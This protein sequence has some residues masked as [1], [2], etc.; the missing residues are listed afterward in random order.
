[1]DAAAATTEYLPLSEACESYREAWQRLVADSSGNLSHTPDWLRLAAAGHRLLEQSYVFVLQDRQSP[2]AFVPLTRRRIRQFGIPL[3]AIDLSSNLASYH[4]EITTTR[5]S[6]EIVGHIIASPEIDDWDF[7]RIGSLLDTEASADLLRH[8]AGNG[9][10]CFTMTAAESP[11]VS[12]GTDWESYLASKHSNFR[13]KIRKRARR[14]DGNEDLEMR[15]LNSPSDIETL[16]AAIQEIEAHS[17]KLEE[18]IAIASDPAE[19]RFNEQL[20]EFLANHEM[21]HA[22]V[23]Y[24]TD[25]PIAYCVCGL[26]NG[27]MGHLKTSFDMRFKEHAP[28]LTVI[29]HSVRNAFE[30]GA[31]EYDFL[32]GADRHKL[33]WSDTVRSHLDVFVYNK[34]RIAAR[35]AASLKRLTARSVTIV[36]A[37]RTATSRQ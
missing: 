13:Y 26:W 15:W 35:V 4:A 29:D 5:P 25:Q 23:L 28:G 10:P 6:T 3:N 24:L 36:N 31:A 9:Y 12:I 33:A 30:I 27:W 17:W 34:D 32:G 22:N 7:F 2:I 19:Q 21:L 37:S 18:G 14:M 11:Y 8:L 20:F 16:L 1:M